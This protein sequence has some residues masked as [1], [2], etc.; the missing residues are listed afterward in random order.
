MRFAAPRVLK[1]L[2]LVTLVGSLLAGCATHG[3]AVQGAAKSGGPTA[4]ESNQA[5]DTH[6]SLFNTPYLVKGSGKHR[7]KSQWLKKVSGDEDLQLVFRPALTADK[8]C[9]AGRDAVYCF[10]RDSGKALWK[11]KVRDLSAGI[12]LTDTA[13][14]VGTDEGE[15][16]ALDI[17]DGTE[18]WRSTVGGEI[19]ALVAVGEVAT[20]RMLVAHSSSG[21]LTGLNAEDGSSVWIQ[22]QKVPR[23]TLRGL[24]TPLVVD[25]LVVT[26][27]DNGRVMANK[28]Q[29]GSIVWQEDLV[30]PT[31]R[32]ELERLADIDGA[33]AYYR[34][35]VFAASWG[36]SLGAWSL[37]KGRSLWRAEI[38]SVTGVAA[39]LRRVYVTDN[40]NALHSLDARSGRVLWK[41]DDLVPEDEAD[42]RRVVSTS[43]ID[44]RPLVLDNLGRLYL[45][46]RATGEL[47]FA[48]S[49]SGE[50]ATA[51][52]VDGNSL[53]TLSRSGSLAL[54]QLED[55][56]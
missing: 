1:P 49:L 13:A 20:G 19:L 31:G 23:L 35:D 44:G 51:P 41:R 8:A 3:G 33:L 29:D 22:E 26:G 18:Q 37:K 54:W 9:A 28:L 47:D 38:A 25:E 34:G 12:V 55:N 24:S 2:L 5:A 10:D 17:V 30:V 7:L 14:Y 16:V 46:E 4:A 40:N 45:Y 6:P 50:F 27:F 42:D 48:T 53:L 52:A 56:Q 32:S 15:I 21:L 11:R 39:D 36:G 43:V